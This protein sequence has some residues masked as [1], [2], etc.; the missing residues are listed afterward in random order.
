MN[1]NALYCDSQDNNLNIV[2]LYLFTLIY[3]FE[4]RE[5]TDGIILDQLFLRNSLGYNIIKEMRDDLK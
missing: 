4:I 3:N 5:I 2:V 1:S